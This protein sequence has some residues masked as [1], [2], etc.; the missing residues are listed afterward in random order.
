[1]S[2][3][4]S[5]QEGDTLALYIPPEERE[6]HTQAM[7]D[8]HAALSRVGKEGLLHTCVSILKHLKA[9][10]TRDEYNR[11]L[12]QLLITMLEVKNIAPKEFERWKDTIAVFFS[13]W[14]LSNS[15]EH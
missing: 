12:N 11:V 1:M 15:T 2:K 9:A 10:E 8:L 4:T 6:Q 5:M 3:E 13:R 14:P 7:A